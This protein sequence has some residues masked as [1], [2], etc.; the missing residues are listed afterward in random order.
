MSPCWLR[1]GF[2]C[3]SRH[4]STRHN[5]HMFVKQPAARPWRQHSATKT[6]QHVCTCCQPYRPLQQSDV[7][8]GPASQQVRATPVSVKGRTL[9]A[10]S[11]HP[12]LSSYDAIDCTQRQPPLHCITSL[13]S[14]HTLPTGSLSKKVHQPRCQTSTWTNW[15]GP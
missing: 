9:A 15:E 3:L 11:Q 6:K 5:A 14:V 7:A 10:S 8:V 12:R 2:R 13:S 1:G 4:T